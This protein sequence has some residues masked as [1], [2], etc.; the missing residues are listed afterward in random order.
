MLDIMQSDTKEA[1]PTLDDK[2]FSAL[3]A[4]QAPLLLESLSHGEHDSLLFK[5]FI[6]HR[7]SP[8]PH[9]P[10]LS[11]E[12]IENAIEQCLAL[13]DRI[14]HKESQKAIRELY[15]HK[16][17]ETI[18]VQRMLKAVHEGDADA[19][20][21]HQKA[22]FG[23]IDTSVI[24]DIVRPRIKRNISPV[25]ASLTKVNEGLWQRA[26]EL[27]PDI[28]LPGLEKQ[29]YHAEEIVQIWNDALEERFRSLGWKAVL[30]AQHFRIT[31]AARPRIIHI[32]S[33]AIMSAAGLRRL[34]AHEVG[35]HITRR[36]AGQYAPLKLLRMGTAHVHRTEEGLALMAEQLVL[37]SRTY[38]GIDKYVAIATATGT[39]DGTPKDFSE[40]FDVLHWYFL[41]RFSETRH[42][43]QAQELATKLAWVHTRSV[44][45]TCPPLR[46]DMHFI[47]SKIYVEGNKEVWRYLE[48]HSNKDFLRL[49]TGRCTPDDLT[50]LDSLLDRSC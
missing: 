30:S 45:R 4:I 25:H 6:E 38:R 5:R 7:E 40:T 26:Q 24:E 10:K 27:F 3:V 11:L 49:F 21:E 29:Q 14:I 32:P 46:K 8:H 39:L 16:I 22:L 41:E 42:Q 12:K 2:W 48:E 1:H 47:R 44:F 13:L 17:L 43:D 28:Y 9:Y 20:T 23:E 34:F 15:Q 33:R 35:T 50:L 19:F 31:V 36:A 37:D 18:E